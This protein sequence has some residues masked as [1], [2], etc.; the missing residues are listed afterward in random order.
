MMSKT[1]LQRCYVKF[2]FSQLPF[3][4]SRVSN[5]S[6]LPS[7]FHLSFSLS[8]CV[9]RRVSPPTEAFLCPSF[10][11]I[12]VSVFFCFSFC[13]SSSSVL[14][15]T[16]K[17]ASHAWTNL[18]ETNVIQ[19]GGFFQLFERLL[20]WKRIYFRG[21]L[22]FCQSAADFCSQLH[23]EVGEKIITW[24]AGRPTLLWSLS[25]LFPPKWASAPRKEE[26]K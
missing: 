8:P 11:S 16:L 14:L 12:F 6:N 15:Q 13:F 9:L 22:K 18:I 7:F 17:G 3:R 26:N 21:H 19:K 5:P 1:S 20:I 2:K 4:T 24:Q 23:T 10:V 25:L